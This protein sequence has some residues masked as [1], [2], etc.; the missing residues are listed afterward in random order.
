MKVNDMM[1]LLYSYADLVAVLNDEADTP[2]R[3]ISRQARRLNS[4]QF[5]DWKATAR[6]VQG[7]RLNDAVLRHGQ[8]LHINYE[9]LYNEIR[10]VLTQDIDGGDVFKN[11]KSE[12]TKRKYRAQ[13]DQGHQ[14]NDQN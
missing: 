9:R 5:L 13:D 10:G 4:K 8:G 3:T 1:A 11:V 6:V 7:Q 12:E 14:F 2:S